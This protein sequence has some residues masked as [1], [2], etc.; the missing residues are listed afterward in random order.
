MKEIERFIA[1]GRCGKRYTVSC[2]QE[3]I[4]N[5]GEVLSPEVK[6]YRTS[7]G[8]LLKAIDES[9]FHILG[10]DKVIYK[11]TNLKSL[12]FHHHDR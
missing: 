2:L 1:E 11:N 3:I 6:H 12:K 10:S 4:K 9:T 8:E 7:D 5:D